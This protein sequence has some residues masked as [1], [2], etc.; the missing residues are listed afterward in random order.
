MAEAVVIRGLNKQFSSPDSPDRTVHAVRDVNLTV[1][2]GQLVTLLGPSGCGKTTLLR[3]IAGFEEPTSGDI[4]FGDRR[5]NDVA[6][7]RRDAAMVFQSYAIF[8]HLSVYE[9]V[10][11]GLRLKSLPAADLKAK[12]DRILEITGL[13]A[14]QN[15]SPNQLSGGQQQRVALARA[16]VMEPK[17]LLFDEPL[18]NLDAK[19]RETMRVEI[20]ELQQRLGITA[21][22]VTH[23]QIEAMSISDRIVVMNGGVVEQVGAPWEVYARPATRFVADFIG[24]AN[25][26][27]G[28][29]VDGG[30]E[31]AGQKF[32]LA[33]PTDQPNGSDVE[34]VLRPEAVALSADS[35]VFAA[36]VKRAMFLGNV[37]EYLLEVDGIGEWLVDVSNPGEVGLHERGSRIFVSPSQASLHVLP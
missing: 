20:R 3:M 23:D 29:V 35:G 19:L 17:V 8:P 11:F 33:H 27:P 34:L 1:E 5:M 22:Y 14:M 24:K 7:N 25:F 13:T 21:L 9:N 15:R 28:K 4:M 12:A 10:V 6:P 2:P 26:V 18:S 31:I 32:S 37:A 16:I 30:V 36:T